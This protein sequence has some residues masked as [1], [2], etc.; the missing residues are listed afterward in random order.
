[1]PPTVA[2]EAA[3]S[4]NLLPSSILKLLP[5]VSSV[6][7]TLI[8]SSEMLIFSSSLIEASAATRVLN[9]A[10]INLEIIIFPFYC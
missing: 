7:T 10:V 3:P 6:M 1:M 5:R 9:V 4:P 2:P 8:C